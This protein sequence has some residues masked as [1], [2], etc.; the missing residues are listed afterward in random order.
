MPSERWRALGPG[1]VLGVLRAELRKAKEEVVIVGPFV[2]DYFASAVVSACSPRVR[3]RVLARP[4]NSVEPGFADHAENALCRFA[5]RPATEVRT[6][7]RL[8]AKVAIVDGTHVFCG[9]PTG[10]DTALM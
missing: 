3:L 1:S 9:A 4:V 10:I 8:H 2:D 5:A 7:A 6:L